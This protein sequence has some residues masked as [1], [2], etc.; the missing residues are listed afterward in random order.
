MINF[1]LE[2][3]ELTIHSR[4]LSFNDIFF[5]PQI[6]VKYFIFNILWIKWFW[7]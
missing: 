4:L 7:L 5:N 2:K 3:P 6:I 1:H